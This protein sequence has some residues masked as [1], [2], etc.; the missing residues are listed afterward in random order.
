[1]TVDEMTAEETIINEMTVDYTIVD[2]T[3]LN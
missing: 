1:M 2:E 3:H